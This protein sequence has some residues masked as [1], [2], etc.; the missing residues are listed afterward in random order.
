MDQK[1]FKLT[2]YGEEKEYPEGTAYKEVAADF[3]NKFP[4][5]IL[6]V[7]FEGVIKELDNLVDHDGTV[8]FITAAEREGKSVYRRSL[9]MLLQA[10]LHDMF[11]EL[12]LIVNHSID[13]GYYCE[14]L[15]NGKTFLVTQGLL[16]NVKEKMHFF[17]EQDLPIERRTVTTQDAIYM[18]R[19]RKKAD[20][21]QFLR[22]RRNSKVNIYQLDGYFD[23]SYSYL[24]SSTGFLKYF[25]L[26]T[27]QNGFMLLYPDKDSRKV[28]SF[29]PSNQLFHTLNE[30]SHWGEMMGIRTV[31]S[32]NNAITKG[33]I[34]DMIL[35]QEALMESKIAQM[36]K[37]ITDNKE[38][39]FI[40]VAGPSSSGKTTFSRRLAIQLIAQ[41]LKPYA[42]SLDDFYLNRELTPRDENGEWDFECL[43]ALDV[44]LFNMTMSG[45]L[46]GEEVEM[47]KFNFKTG[48]REY[49]GRSLK[50]NRDNVLI[51]EGIHGLNEQLSYDIPTESKFKVYISAL[52]QL[53]IDYQNNLSTSDCRLIR[54][55]VRDARTRNSS[56]RETL[57]RWDSV[58][59]GEERNIF[60][61]Q[62]EA[63]IIFNSALIYELS[64]LKLYAEPLL[65][66]IESDCIEYVEAKRLLKF[67]DFFLP[68]PAESISNTSILREFIGGGCFECGNSE[69]KQWI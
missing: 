16:S 34:Q 27:Y 25:E 35:V 5:D 33:R 17:V 15:K 6:L 69:G 68:V 62:E 43:E 46:N 22:F 3:Q 2:I 56:A 8:R 21:E 64:V 44:E 19:E 28:P 60:P 52:T 24:L 23:L 1:T 7:L 9:S 11:P 29:N 14:L 51:I 36:A 20:K 38:I 66:D 42:I 59:R 13:N 55:M 10:A 40:L 63:D 53:N 57:A 45:L 47:P 49:T 32:L 18:C 54:R 61:Y 26:Q 30:A 48:H 41:G 65:Y 58:R 12:E 50:L 4:D 37:V 39:K 31:G 67:L